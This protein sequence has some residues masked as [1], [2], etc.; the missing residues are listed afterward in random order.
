MHQDLITINGSYSISQIRFR[1]LNKLKTCEEQAIYHAILNINQIKQFSFKL[2]ILISSNQS[3]KYD[4]YVIIF[5][6]NQSIRF[7]FEFSNPSKWFLSSVSKHSNR[8]SNYS[9]SILIIRSLGFW[10]KIEH[11]LAFRVWIDFN[12]RSL[13]FQ[14]KTLRFRLG[15]KVLWF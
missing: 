7:K 5:N 13:R 12:I 15:F 10:I 4:F 9:I 14:F 2:S 6:F 11:V 1:V 8:S 3:Q